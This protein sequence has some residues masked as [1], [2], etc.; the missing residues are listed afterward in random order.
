ME[1]V[2]QAD[3]IQDNYKYSDPPKKRQ[4]KMNHA[5]QDDGILNKYD[6]P[7]IA[8]V[9]VNTGHLISWQ[10]RDVVTCYIFVFSVCSCKVTKLSL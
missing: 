9:I 3:S 2:Q 6:L 10:G 5:L 4:P 8:Q 1:I 7:L